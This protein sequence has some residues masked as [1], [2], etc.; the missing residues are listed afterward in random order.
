MT[1]DAE[2][3]VTEQLAYWGVDNVTLLDCWQGKSW[4]EEQPWRE[5]CML[6]WWREQR[7]REPEPLDRP[8]DEA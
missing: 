5:D 3:K 7:L 2:G 4:R 6:G 1:F 8:D